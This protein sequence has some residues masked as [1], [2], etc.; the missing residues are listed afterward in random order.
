M[1]TFKYAKL[2][3][4][5]IEKFGTEGKFAKALGKNVNTVSRKLCGKV[6][7]SSYDIEQ[8]CN[9]LDIPIEEAGSYFFA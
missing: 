1:A 9:A 4:K 5:I 3:G 7:F 6:R 2:K 8:W